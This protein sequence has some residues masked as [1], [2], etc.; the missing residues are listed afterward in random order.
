MKK[1]C[2]TT[3]CSTT[4]NKQFLKC[5]K[6]YKKVNK[7]IT[8]KQKQK[9]ILTVVQPDNVDTFAIDVYKALCVSKKNSKLF[10]NLKQ[11]Y[12]STALH[13]STTVRIKLSV[14]GVLK[15]ERILS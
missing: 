4:K 13:E 12:A 10:K 14:I 9:P 6:T 2:S 7:V 11:L 1:F 15:S 8:K 5:S 3:K